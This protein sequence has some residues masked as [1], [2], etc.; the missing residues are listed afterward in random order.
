M[1]SNTE[2]LAQE[3]AYQQQLPMSI[4]QNKYILPQ[5]ENAD[6]LQ[7]GDG[8]DEDATDEET[9]DLHVYD[10]LEVV[11]PPHTKWNPTMLQSE[12]MDAQIYE[13]EGTSQLVSDD[14][15]Y[16]PNRRTNL[17][18][19]GCFNES[20]QV[21]IEEYYEVPKD[22]SHQTCADRQGL[23]MRGGYRYVVDTSSAVVVTPSMAVNKS[24]EPYHLH[25]QDGQN[26]TV[27]SSHNQALQF[28]SPETKLSRPTSVFTNNKSE[29]RS[30]QRGF[31]QTFENSCDSAGDN[32]SMS[33]E[34]K[35]DVHAR[36][37][38]DQRGLRNTQGGPSQTQSM[39]TSVLSSPKVSSNQKLERLTDNIV[40]RN[41][42]TL[43]YNT[44][45]YGSY[46]MVHAQKEGMPHS[47]NKVHE[48][49]KETAITEHQKDST[50]PK[51]WW[52]RKTKQLRVTQIGKE[53]KVQWKEYP[54]PPQQQQPPA[55]GVS[56]EWRGSLSYPLAR[57]IAGTQAKPQKMTSSQPLPHTVH[58]N[59]NLSTSSHFLP[60]LQQR[61]QDTVINVA[62]PH[63]APQ[64]SP[65]T[66]AEIALSH[67]KTALHCPLFFV[68]KD[69][70]WSS[71][72]VHSTLFPQSLPRT[73]TTTLSM[74][75]GSYT[76]LPP[77][78]KP[79]TGKESELSPCQSV[80]TA[81]PIH[82]SN[83]DG[84]L[85]QM[86]KQKQ[87]RAKV[88]YKAYSLK[89]YKQLKSDI[90]LQGLGPDYK[91]T[92]KTKMKRQRLYSIV[93]REQNRGMS[94]IPFL[95]AKDPEVNDKNVPR[96][97]ALEYA[98]TIEKPPVQF[99][100][101]QRQK[102][103]SKGF[104]ECTPFLEDLDMS[105]PVPLDVLRKRHEEEKKAVALFR[106]V[107]GV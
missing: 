90:N 88:T 11:A 62:S 104:T 50:D 23:I 39:N 82:R 58:L 10:S 30:L 100:P 65:T 12:Y 8:K 34:L 31:R 16:D 1:E 105:Q 43:G 35:E 70:K 13:R 83:S 84:Y 96:M 56:A 6:S 25:Q 78:G 22:I 52:L 86:E 69:Q 37:F 74:C 77:I 29:N 63:D 51:L 48:T 103:K 28:I 59:I 21:S 87:L 89:D 99:E 55:I 3:M 107:H 64:L 40:E 24:E 57:P 79:I 106:K 80:S 18:G 67:G 97:R 45:K 53:K 19:A 17:K 27:M 81:Y 38:Q 73:P 93:I 95:P 94:R 44:S 7:H 61:G 101:K 46:A 42:I 68:G 33:P 49:L 54:N 60:L 91:A 4:D 15:Y 20:P 71:N 98:K 36:Y 92:E 76:V 75:S 5:K 102:H 9:E 85:V 14:A 26:N 32:V 41:K 72:E 66:E 2:N 47:V